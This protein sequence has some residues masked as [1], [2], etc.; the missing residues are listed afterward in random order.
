MPDFYQPLCPDK[1]YH[2]YSHGTGNEK[3]FKEEKNYDFFLRK[4]V[5]HTLP[6]A[7]TFAF[8]LLPDQFRFII[9]IKPIEHIVDHFT[10]VKS[11][12]PFLEHLCSDFIMERFSNWLNSYVKSFNKMYDR[13]GSLFI[14]YIRRAEINNSEQLCSTIS[15]LHTTPIE[16]HF[17][18]SP[19]EWKYC[20]YRTLLNGPHTILLNET[21]MDLFGSKRRFIKYHQQPN[22]LKMAVIIP[23]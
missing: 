9:R 13:K 20:S 23:S 3:I 7:D 21:V 19:E 16:N 1:N 11:N 2:I 8:S 15:Y 10:L 14:D 5:Q 4:Y 18:S 17:C 12:K 22:N 6:V